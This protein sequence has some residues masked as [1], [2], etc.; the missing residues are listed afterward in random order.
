[1]KTHAQTW[2]LSIALSSAIAS[3][4]LSFQAPG[5]SWFSEHLLYYNGF[6][7]GELPEV[8]VPAAQETRRHAYRDRPPVHEVGEGF[9]GVALSLE[10]GELRLESEEFSPHNPLTISFWWTLPKDHVEND[11]FTLVTLRGN[12]G[13]LIRNFARGGPWAGLNRTAGILH[14]LDF[15]DI[16]RVHAPYDQELSSNLA[17]Q[18]GVW[19]HTALV[20]SNGN[21]IQVYTNGVLEFEFTLP[22]RN[23]I[24]EDG[25]ES[26]SFGRGIIVDEIAV[27]GRVVAA[28]GI[29]RYYEA[30]R[31]L[32]EYKDITPEGVSVDETN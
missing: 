29:Q 26:I 31:K 16:P 13:A 28:D 14:V 23:F 22:G 20:F 2:I 19:H 5:P 30:M 32:H 6:E 27:I 12:D 9:L 8:N 1:M 7:H 21:T 15:Q 4:G 3:T 11:S 18:A 17:L 10:G 24:P 25:V